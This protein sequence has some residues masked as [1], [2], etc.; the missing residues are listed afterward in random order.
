MFGKT[1]GV[2][3][4]TPAGSR[5]LDVVRSRD[6]NRSGSS[7]S[8]S[9]LAFDQEGIAKLVRLI[10]ARAECFGHARQHSVTGKSPQQLEMTVAYLMH[11]REQC[12][13]DSQGRLG[14]DASSRNAMSRKDA[15]VCIGCRFEC[16]DNAR[17]NGDDA[18]A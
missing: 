4:G 15:I 1:D 9:L 5:S 7:I 18:R 10:V 16:T 17:P 14:P 11:A 8:R 6:S 2:C 12:I 13:H 3:D